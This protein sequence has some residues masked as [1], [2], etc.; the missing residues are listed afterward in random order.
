MPRLLVPIA[1]FLAVLLVSLASACGGSGEDEPALVFATLQGVVERPLDDA[2]HKIIIPVTPGA[3]L[4]SPVASPD[5]TRIAYTVAPPPPVVDGSR[6]VSNDIHIALRDGS[7]SAMV[8]EHQIPTEVTT[9]LAWLNDDSLVAI[10]RHIEERASGGTR[11]I[12]WLARIDASS[13]A[14]TDLMPDVLSFGL[15]PDGSRVAY[16]LLESPEEQ[17]L[18]IADIDGGRTARLLDTTSGLDG[19]WSPTFSID[20]SSL[21]FAAHEHEETQAARPGIQTVA[22]MSDGD[23]SDLWSI[24]AEGGT[25][26]LVAELELAE[27]DLALGDT[28]D[29]LY[30]ASGTI[31]EVDLG[32]GLVTTLEQGDYTSGLDVAE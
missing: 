16:I 17:P 22:F 23:L 8:Y 10:I 4:S 21:Y 27:P 31:L 20:G 7:E 13:G 18:Y 12:W 26:T 14:R 30:A 5:G 29:L 2:E 32:S 1:C 11:L 28:A 24:P 19:F 6:V 9:S 15:S 3:T 25:P